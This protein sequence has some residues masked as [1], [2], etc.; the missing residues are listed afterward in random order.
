MTQNPAFPVSDEAAALHAELLTLDSHIDI[1]WPDRNDVFTDTP[2]RHVDF[3]KMKRG[4]VSAGCFVAYQAQGP[5]TPEDHAR[6]AETGIAMLET[7][8]AMART[9]NGLTARLCI[10]A[11]DVEQSHRDNVLAVIPAVENGYA[12]GE[13][14]SLLARFR[15]LGARYVTLTHNGHNALGDSSRPAS[16]LGDRETLHGGLSALGRQA[17]TEM[18]RLGLIVDVSHTSRDTMLQATDLSSVPVV[19]THACVK[20]LCDHPR[21]L[22]DTQLDALK[23][24]GGVIQITAMGTFLLPVNT[25]RT[26]EASIADFADHLDYVVRRI[27]PEHVGISSDFDGG[28]HLRG[29]ENAAESPMLTAELLR[30]GYDRSEITAFWGGNFLRVLRQAEAA[31]EA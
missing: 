5:L 21:N 16:R 3:P 7:I 2:D 12:M 17:V 22:D 8:R 6:A 20:A 30:R 18:N 24:S 19:A 29:W 11:D 9:E 13:D 23:A 10:L 27:G 28:G 25:L 4:G 14:L 31:A 15:A 1:P 26:R